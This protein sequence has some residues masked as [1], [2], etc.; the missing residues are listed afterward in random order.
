MH[1]THVNFAKGFRGG[2]RQT[3]NLMQGLAALGCR[4]RLVCRPS[5]ELMR[6]ARDETDV[7]LLPS[8]HPLLTHIGVPGTD[9]IH[10]HE[11]RGA[12]WAWLEHRLRGTP[13]LITRRVLDPI[14][15]SRLTRKVY[16]DATSLV[17]VSADA[18]RRL[19][20][21]TGRDVEV[22]LSSCAPIAA[23]P[24]AVR[25]VRRQ[26]GGAPVI[27]HVGVLHDAVKGQ[28]ILIAAFRELASAWPQ[29]RLVLVGGG[30]DRERLQALAAGDERILFVGQQKDVAAWLAAMDVFVFPSRMEALGT[31]VLDAMMLGVPV[32]ASTVGGLPE[33]T[34]DGERGLSVAGED[35]REWAATIGRLLSD[36]ALRSRLVEAGRAFA[37]QNDVDAH[38]KRYLSLYRKL[39]AARG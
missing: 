37:A 35:P 26:V 8:A 4:Q 20:L 7:D 38:A 5:G 33:L 18:A 34:G 19:S 12:Y 3:L 27:G 9:L 15:S 21:Q 1:I 13:Y 32:V 14:S 31:S 16:A 36:A 24:E 28:S 10:V 6:R 2:E 22:V 25:A 11:A 17:G 29:A 30:P 23:A 39:L